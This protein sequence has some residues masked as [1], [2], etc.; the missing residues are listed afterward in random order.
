MDSES[1]Y[2][3]IGQLVETMP[4]FGRRGALDG[5]T[6]KWLGRACAL[7]EAAGD[8]TDASNFRIAADMIDSALRE[9]NVHTVIAILHRALARAE[10]V[11]PAAARG[12]FIPVGAQFDVYQA[13]GMVLATAKS[14]LLVIDPYIDESFLTKFGL[15]A[16]EGVVLRLIGAERFKDCGAR[17]LQA[18]N[19]W[20]KQY[21]SNRP[22]ES[23]RST[24]NALHDRLFILDKG[25]EAWSFGQSL[26]DIAQNSPT[27]LIRV[28]DNILSEKFACY[29]EIWGNSN[30]L[31]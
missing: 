4:N 11:A 1:L 22:I 14:D 19:A 2:R 7:V 17:L 9:Q 25:T 24:A 8:K 10:L 20:I 21:G 5:E 26:K 29:E 6:H 15:L 13:V 27:S 12:A 23:R 16:A 18:Q 3:Q 31:V 30:P 28:P